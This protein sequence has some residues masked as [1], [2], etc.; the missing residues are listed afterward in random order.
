MDYAEFTDEVG[1]LRAGVYAGLPV[2]PA[3]E[4]D[5]GGALPGAGEA[6]WRLGIDDDYDSDE[7]FERQFAR[8]MDAVDSTEV[9]AIVI[10]SWDSPW[11]VRA[12]LPIGLL[13]DNADR[14]PALRSIFLGAITSDECEISWIKQGD[15]TPLL[16]AFP[17]LERL[18]V[19]GGDGLKLSPVRHDALRILRFESGGLPAR[20]V[21]AVGDSELPALECLEMWLGIDEYGGDTTVADLAP[22]LSGERLPSLRHLGLQDTEIQD[23]LAEAV[24][25]APVVARLSSLSL[26]MGVLTDA[27]AEALLSGQPLTHLRRLDLHHHFLGDDMVQRVAKALP[28]VD[29]DL[30]EQKEP[31]E[32]WRYVAVAE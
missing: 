23:Q 13:A 18:E 9:T 24:A 17:R 3:P 21:R 5:D 8:F 12:D 6:A 31:E 32:E 30:S 14:F 22:I 20:V 1:G 28:G 7:T 19:R 11:D 26:A 16:R 10:G 4:D 2:T 27:G 29:V 15:V 25:S